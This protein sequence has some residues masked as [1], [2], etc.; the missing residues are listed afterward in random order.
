MKGGVFNN[1]M[2]IWLILI[3]ALTVALVSA[4]AYVFVP[5]P[6]GLLLVRFFNDAV[7]ERRLFVQI[8]LCSN[9]SL[10]YN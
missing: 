5:I 10:A 8:C 2:N 4:L 1:E 6:T 3:A 9:Q 7:A